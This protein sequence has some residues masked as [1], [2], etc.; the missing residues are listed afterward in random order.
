MIDARLEEFFLAKVLCKKFEPSKGTKKTG[1]F[2][3]NNL[4]DHYWD[5]T[6]YE[7]PAIFDNPSLKKRNSN[8]SVEIL[9]CPNITDFKL[10]HFHEINF[11][12]IQGNFFLSGWAALL[13]VYNENINWKKAIEVQ[14]L[15][16]RGSCCPNNTRAKKKSSTHY[17]AFQ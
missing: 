10:P 4:N 14:P 6:L 2:Y 9:K 11:L 3:E 12:S 17:R 16:V 13:C 7:E 5:F 1:Y 15:Y 8:D